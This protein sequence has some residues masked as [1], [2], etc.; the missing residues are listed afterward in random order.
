MWVAGIWQSVRLKVPVKQA[1]R[2]R[3]WLN[4]GTYVLL[5]PKYPNHAWSYVS[6]LARFG[7]SR[8]EYSGEGVPDA[9][10]HG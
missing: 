1:K 3:L 7:S 5:R 6:A 8:I 4:A 2:G 10:Y 9:E